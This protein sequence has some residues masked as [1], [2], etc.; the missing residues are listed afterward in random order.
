[1][2][3]LI[4]FSDNYWII[5]EL[6][7]NNK[8]QFRVQA[9]NRYGWSDYSPPSDWFDLTTTAMFAHQEL[10]IVLWVFPPI[11]IISFVIIFILFCSKYFLLFNS[12]IYCKLLKNLFI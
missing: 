1:M 9:K 6:G 4:Y 2:L 5:T 10:T 8:Y 3:T 7:T 12:L 11:V